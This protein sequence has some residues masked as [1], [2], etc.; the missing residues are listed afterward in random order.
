MLRCTIVAFVLG[1]LCCAAWAMEHFNLEEI[2]PGVFAHQ[3]QT[4]LMNDENK[5]DIANIGFIVGQEAVAVVDTGGSPGLG[6]DFLLA[7]QQKTGKPIR[8]VINTH[9]HPDHIFGNKAFTGAGALFVGHKNLPRAIAI[10]GPYY[11]DAFR[12]AMKSALDDVTLVPPTLTVA[13]SLTLDLGGREIVLT[14]WRAAHSDSDVTVLD[15]KTGTLFSGDLLFLQHVPIVDASLLGFLEVAD[16]LKTI[17]AVR[18]VPGHGPVVAPWPKALEDQAAYLTKLTTDLRAAIKR[19]ESVGA[20]AGEAGRSERPKWR[21]FD[22]Y[23]A[24]NATTGFA[25]LEWETP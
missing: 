1:R 3:G 6:K 10:R 14:A 22:D 15:K 4:A 7:L 8:Y 11:I 2:A 9:V 25:E 16:E 24:R 12:P 5:G 19:G 13:D 21:L 20:A 18:V 23:N 17:E